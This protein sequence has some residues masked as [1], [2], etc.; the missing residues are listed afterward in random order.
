MTTKLAGKFSGTIKTPSVSLHFYNIFLIV[1]RRMPWGFI[2]WFDLVFLNSALNN[3]SSALIVS[4]RR[5][6]FVLFF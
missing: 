4:P 5:A 2:P 1:T 3:I 6:A